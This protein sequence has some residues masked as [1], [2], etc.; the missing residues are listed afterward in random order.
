MLIKLQSW[1]LFQPYFMKT[2]I[3]SLKIKFIVKY[4]ISLFFGHFS[5]KYLIHVSIVNFKYF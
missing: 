4:S 1:E 2:R 3:K 5:Q